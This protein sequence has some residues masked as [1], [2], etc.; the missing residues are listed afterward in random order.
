MKP[1]GPRL[2]CFAAAALPL[3]L[4]GCI[5]AA[6]PIA[7]GAVV[8]GKTAQKRKPAPARAALP[9]PAIEGRAVLVTGMTALPPPGTDDGGYGAFV[10]FAR[11]KAAQHK[12]GG[13]SVVLA[14]GSSLSAPRFVPCG[15]LAPAVIFDLD[16]GK[17]RFDPAAPGTAQPGLAEQLAGLRAAG[18][19]VIWAS[20]LPVDR[21]QAVYDR[22][23]D[24]G[25]DPTG[26][27]RVLLMRP[28]DERK[29][30]RRLAATRDWCVIAMAGD[31]DGDFDE[32]FDYLR[33]PDYAVT[34]AFLKNNGW[35]L[36]PPPMQ[37][38][39]QP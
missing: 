12:D 7:A 16:P 4:G 34:L 18:V 17:A 11:D 10:R 13:N 14:E 5:A 28:G 25:L 19:T 3:L 33:N 23:R 24:S 20:A 29:Q 39:P 38:I 9:P 2:A 27:D 26:I 1:V 15:S 21:A 31:R 37:E 36:A 6:V 22:L 35:F 30:T 8:A 32:L